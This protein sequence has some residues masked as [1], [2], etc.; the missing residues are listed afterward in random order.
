MSLLTGITGGMGSGKTLVASI[1]FEFGAHILDADAICR[2]LVEPGQP[3]LKEISEYFGENIIDIV[4][5]GD[6]K[7]N[8]LICGFNKKNKG[9]NINSCKTYIRVNDLYSTERMQELL[10]LQGVIEYVDT[11]EKDGALVAIELSDLKQKNYTHMEIHP[12]FLF[13]VMGNQIIYPENNPL[14]RDL[15]SCGQSKQAVSIYHSNF[16]SRIDKSGLILNYGQIPLVKSR[17]MKYINNEEHPYGEN[18]IVAIACYSSYNVEDSILFNQASVDRGLFRTTYYNMYE[19]REESST[20]GGTTIDSRFANIYKEKA[21][22]IK[23]GY[24][25]SELN[26]FGIINENTKIDDK[27]V[28]IGKISTNLSEPNI[29]R[30]A[31]TFPKK[32]QLGYIDK[33][34]I[35]ENEEGFRL[36]KV[37]VREERIPSIGD[38]FCSRCGQKGTVGRVIP[39]GDMPF[40]SDGMRPDIIINPHALPSRMTIGQLLETVIGKSC[41]LYGAFGDCTAFINKGS[42][43][44]IFGKLLSKQGFHTSGN[45]ILY[46]GETGEQLAMQIFIGPTYYMRLKHMVKDKINFRAQGPRT[47]L[48]RQ[49]DQGRANDGGLRIGELERDAI[50][51]HGLSY[52]L[53]E[54]LMVRGDEYRMAICNLTGFISIYNAN[55]DLFVSP[56]ADGPVKYTGALENNFNIEKLTKYGRNFSIINIPYAFKLLIQELATLN[57]QM[58]IITEDNID[59]LHNMQFS[60][61]INDLQNRPVSSDLTPSES[62]PAPEPSAA[63]ESSAA[64]ETS[65]APAKS[66][67]DEQCCGPE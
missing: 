37:R 28:I 10:P 65:A 41:S 22:G 24:D 52:F 33:S 55:L 66:A 63:P 7:W 64:H 46:N 2:K 8:E 25:Y 5:T 19:N 26:D 18:V 32:G 50:I 1:F 60:E 56:F 17:Y 51:A 31:S 67:S 59:Q 43:Y 58:R 29:V 39:E 9:F 44:D 48:S 62:L 47:L 6:Y 61:I 23:P 35:T 27:L 45:E 3:A 36:A 40:T 54:S 53:K 21:V 4:K 57:V 49:P 34:F 16:L 11:S 30:D 20:V 42:K 13:G 14:P 12:S 15:F 38:K